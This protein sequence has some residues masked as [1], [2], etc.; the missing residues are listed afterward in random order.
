M[1]VVTGT[2]AEYGLL[3][4]TLAAIHAHPRLT[5][6]L[7]VTGMHLLKRFGMT[8]QQVEQDGWRIDARIPMQCGDDAPMDQA[9]GLARGVSGM[10]AYFERARTEIVVVLGD[11]IEA[12]AGALA[13]ATTGRL[14]VH[15]HGGD[16]APG[17]MDDALRDA[18]TKVA[19]VHLA[20]T[21][22][23]ANRIIG[24]GETA[25][26]VHVVGAPGL[27][28]LLAVANNGRPKCDPT[29]ALVVFHASGRPA[30]TEQ[31]TMRAILRAVAAQGLSATVIYPNTDRGHSG[32]VAAID[33]AG[34][35]MNGQL[36]VVRSMGRT[37]YLHALLSTGVV[38][39]NSSSGIIEAA[40][41]GVP[42]VN[43]GGRQAG[44]L[45]GGSS[46]VQSGESY[47]AI[48]AAIGRARR[49][50]PDKGMVRSPYGD[51]G[52]G[53]RIAAIIAEMPMTGGFRRKCV[54][55]T[56]A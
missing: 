23:A 41:V 26:R 39:G 14:L 51:G 5:L 4:T 37:A 24:M 28:E 20:A 52:A 42:C 2:R 25:D 43:I 30:E 35:R 46:V 13:A 3:R 22:A 40:S 48:R 53:E 18:I 31:A 32:I 49:R 38:V 36:N 8:V 11:R 10:A 50:R 33:D 29:R 21:R 34:Q 45:P 17:D 16:V 27:D 54:V 44:R 1:A 15:V 19:H 55:R 9:Q 56:K 7:V 47:R 6:Q 12:L